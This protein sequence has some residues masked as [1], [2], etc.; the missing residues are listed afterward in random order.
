MTLQELQTAFRGLP[1]FGPPWPWERRLL[2]LIMNSDKGMDPYEVVL[3][4]IDR[5]ERVQ[6]ILPYL[7]D[8]DIQRVRSLAATI[9]CVTQDMRDV[10]DLLNSWVG[11]QTIKKILAGNQTK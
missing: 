4:V 5:P 9:Q 2:E 1:P 8:D 10:A 3:A 6:R 11:R 7:V